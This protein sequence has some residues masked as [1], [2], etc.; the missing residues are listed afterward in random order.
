VRQIE[1]P[2]FLLGMPR[3]GTKLLR[4]ILNGHSKIS[5]SD[6]ET[7]FFPYWVSNW[8]QLLP[9]ATHS[10]FVEF[11]ER[12]LKLPFFIQLAERGEGVDRDRWF[13]SCEK[14]TPAA[15]FSGLMRSYLEIP[16]FND[17]VVWG[18]KSPSYIRH[19]PLLV[20]QFPRCRIV[21]IVRDV[22]DYALSLHKAWRKSMIRAAQRW[23]DDVSTA[24][25]HTMLHSAQAM[26][27]RYEDLLANPET[28]VSSLCRF[29]EVRFETDMVRLSRVVENIGEAKDTASIV[30]GNTA[31]YLN[32]MPPKLVRRIETVAG[33]TLIDLGYPCSY[34][35]PA[36]PVANWIMRLLQAADAVNVIWSD[37]RRVGLGRSLRFHLEYFR[38]SG[39]RSG[40][41][42]QAH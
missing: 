11:Y 34:Q 18:D 26:E 22:R 27:I 15:V 4:E 8:S 35:G 30:R 10:G 6:V 12:S 40:R 17:G 32:R 42:R 37:L 41:G 29:L 23:Q 36:H 1:R 31:K 3:S 9:S 14:L 2:I 20:Q 28:V 13:E 19:I 16:R 24:R 39:N 38:T 25:I 7:E 5:F 21:H 33:P